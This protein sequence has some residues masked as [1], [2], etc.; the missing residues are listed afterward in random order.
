ML[1]PIPIFVVPLTIKS[2]FLSRFISPNRTVLAPSIVFISVNEKSPLFIK[3]FPESEWTYPPALVTESAP[4]KTKSFL[5]SRLKSTAS[6]VP[7]TT[8]KSIG[9][10]T[11]E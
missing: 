7:Y 10:F 8:P 5:P 6:I 1:S 4:A 3:I 11:S 9:I 2:G